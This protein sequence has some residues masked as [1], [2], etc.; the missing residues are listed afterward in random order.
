MTL[1]V[2]GTLGLDNNPTI[3]LDDLV[4]LEDPAVIFE[5]ELVDSD[6]VTAYVYTVAGI[7]D[8]R[9]IVQADHVRRCVTGALVGGDAMIVHAKD[10]AEA[11]VIAAEGLL[12]TIKAHGAE[13]A[14]QAAERQKN[15]GLVIASDYRARTRH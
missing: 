14:R 4:R 1:D 2:R 15:A 3:D 13:L 6:N 12:D 10:R 9:P 8:G 7:L 11:D 5:G